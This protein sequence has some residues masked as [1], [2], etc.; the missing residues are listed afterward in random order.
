VKE[1]NLN[2]E[3]LRNQSGEMTTVLGAISSEIGGIR[4]KALNQSVLAR[5]TY[6]GVKQIEARIV[7]LTLMLPKQLAAV[8]TLRSLS[9]IP[10]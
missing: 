4:D 3:G 10:P 8:L 9:L 7:N 2:T 6:D 5:N 1:L